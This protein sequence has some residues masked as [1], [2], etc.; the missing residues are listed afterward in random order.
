MPNINEFHPIAQNI[1]S[2]RLKIDFFESKL[3]AA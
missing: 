1:E 2:E 3:S